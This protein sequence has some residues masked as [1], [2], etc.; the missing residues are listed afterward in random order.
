M[1]DAVQT[2]SR[3]FWFK[4]VGMLQQ[5]WALVDADEEG[6]ATVYFVHD[7]SG[8]FDRMT[9]ESVRYA[10]DGL[11]RNG[12]RRLAAEHKARE[13]LSPPASPFTES[14]HP[15]GPIYSSGRYWK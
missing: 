4:V 12:F 3:D 2:N 1:A 5:N 13:F 15:N 9:V 11:A 14:S 7:G 8:V 6:R 10:E